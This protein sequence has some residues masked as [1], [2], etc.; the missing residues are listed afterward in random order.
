M[1]DESEQTILEHL[2]LSEIDRELIIKISDNSKKI[3]IAPMD[4]G[5]SGSSVWQASWLLPDYTEIFSALHVLKIGN[6]GKL[7]KEFTAIKRIVYHVNTVA[8]VP[9]LSADMEISKQDPERAILCLSFQGP[10]WGGATFSLRHYLQERANTQPPSS[11][12]IR[13]I[14]KT[15]YTNNLKGWHFHGT[16]TT[17][18]KSIADAVH[19]WP[20][21]IT[22]L[23]QAALKLGQA[24]LNNEL[25]A[26]HGIDLD[27]L[28][29]RVN[30]ELHLKRSFSWGPVHGDLH[31]TNVNLDQN[32]NIYVID[33]GN[34][35]RN[36]RGLDF[37]VLEAAIKFAAAPAH[38]PL[39]TFMAYEKYL[40]SND[41]SHISNEALYSEQ[42]NLMHEA[43]HEI[44]QHC[45]QSHAETNKNNYYAGLICV[46]AAFTSIEWLVNRRF[47]F[48]SIAHYIKEIDKNEQ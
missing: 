48:H 22:L 17:K 5:L 40:T 26:I 3:L 28:C 6:T 39:K 24:A 1:T 44:R 38:V 13:N 30:H 25:I 4:K 2:N 33:Y 29:E 34:T 46:A 27:S 31:A 23:K 9:S 7:E 19:W 8:N 41:R 14:I 18:V 35:E 16:H 45:W 32:L 10:E 21:K 12:A 47:L 11:E 37:I 20:K 43:I 15:L 42:M 36:W